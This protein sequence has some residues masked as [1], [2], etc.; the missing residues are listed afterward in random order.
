MTSRLV[1]KV[2]ISW[3]P[4]W[5][6]HI[7]GRY[8]EREVSEDGLP[9]EQRVEAKCNTCGAEWKIGCTSGS[10]RQHIQKFAFI[11]THTD[12]LHVVKK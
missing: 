11:H 6:S 5:A 7:D 9:E 4:E 10:V 1:S 2:W 3:R 8:T 12:P